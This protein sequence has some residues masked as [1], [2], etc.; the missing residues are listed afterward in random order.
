MQGVFCF[1]GEMEEGYLGWIV[2]D[3][4]RFFLCNLYFNILW[5]FQNFFYSFFILQH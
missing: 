2:W 3:R 1:V 5:N 4:F